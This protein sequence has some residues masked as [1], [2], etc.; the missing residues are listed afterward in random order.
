MTTPVVAALAA[1]LLLGATACGDD[2]GGGDDGD[3]ATTSVAPT[4]TTTPPPDPDDLVTAICAARRSRPVP[5]LADPELVE[6]SG[7]VALPGGLWA[8]ND[9]GDEARLFRLDGRGRTTAVVRLP[10][11]TA[12]DWEDL[13]GSGADDE[14]FAGDIGD[15]DGVRPEVTV[16]RVTLPDPA[17]TGTV[18]LPADAVQAITLRYPDGPRDAEALLVDPVTRDLVVVHKR[19]GGPSIVYT[20][21][22]EDWA[23]GEADLVEVGLFDPGASPFDAVT[24]ADTAFDGRAVLIR[25]YAGL[26]AVPRQDDQGLAEAIV[27]NPP[28]DAPTTIEV[29]GEAVAATPEGYVTISEG[30]RPQVNRYVVT[31]PGGGE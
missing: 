26:F 9:S 29:Q 18:D 11:V 10:G 3:G 7:L 5:R 8:H 2:G 6:L 12:T 20:A 25:T 16:L 1:A 30:R 13:A 23:D 31:V 27:A 22:E 14:L 21:A 28:C 4:T 15:N 17:V 24:A 19:F